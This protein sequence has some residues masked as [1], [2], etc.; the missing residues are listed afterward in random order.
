MGIGREQNEPCQITNS[1]SDMAAFC[2]L[3]KKPALDMH[4]VQDR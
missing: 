1:L 2:F 4:F 3:E